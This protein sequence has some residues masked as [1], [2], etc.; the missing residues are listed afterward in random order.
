MWLPADEYLSGNVR[1][2]LKIAQ[3]YAENHAEYAVNVQ[4]LTRVQPKELDAS[5]IEVRIG[6][7]WIEPKYIE[8]FMRETF[9]T[10][11]YLLDRSVMGVQYSGVTGQWNVKGKKRI[12]I[13]R[14]FESEI[15]NR[16]Q[17]FNKMNIKRQMRVERQGYR[18]IV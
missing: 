3:E 4:A 9:Q 11:K 15:Y 7:T 6:A 2:K 13:N 14:F 16:L 12:N 18:V 1:E 5:E 17:F 10:P 8:D